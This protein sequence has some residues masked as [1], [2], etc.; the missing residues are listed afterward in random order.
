MADKKYTYIV[1]I[2]DLE[3]TWRLFEKR[4]K[5]EIRKCP[6]EAWYSF[7]DLELLHGLE[8]FDKFHKET[9][10]DRKIN[11][12]FIYQVWKDWKPNI[13]L[14]Y[15]KGSFALISW[16]KE[17]GYYLMAARNKS[18]KTEGQ[19][20]MILWQVMKDLNELG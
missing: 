18:Y 9:R 19:P 15:C 4:T 2:S 16:G 13:R 5:Y 6:Y 8:D 7:G 20:S 3:M 10:P 11:K 17:K 1:G 12:E 14:Y